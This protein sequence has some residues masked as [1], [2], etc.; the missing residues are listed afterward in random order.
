MC[1]PAQLWEAGSGGAGQ[2]HKTRDVISFCKGRLRPKQR[3]DQPGALPAPSSRG[4]GIRRAAPRRVF[5]TPTQL[6]TRPL[7]CCTNTGAHVRSSALPRLPSHILVHTRKHTR[8]CHPHTS[9]SLSPSPGSHILNGSEGAARPQLRGP[10]LKAYGGARQLG[11]YPQKLGSSLH[12]NEFIN[13]F[14][15]SHHSS[16]TAAE[17]MPGFLGRAVEG[18]ACGFQW[19]RGSGSLASPFAQCPR[20]PVGPLTTCS[21]LLLRLPFQEAGR[22]Q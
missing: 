11:W 17:S 5:P 18:P 10:P 3:V 7:V 4:Q 16:R 6:R 20:G 14:Q 19:V 1:D 8:V 15:R 2:D 21:L 13:Y 9:T 12:V 22:L